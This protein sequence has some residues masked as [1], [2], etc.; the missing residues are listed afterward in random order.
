M[1]DIRGVRYPVAPFILIPSLIALYF[2]YTRPMLCLY[3]CERSS[4]FVMNIIA[5]HPCLA[6]HYT[7][8]I[9]AFPPSACISDPPINP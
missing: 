3:C 9:A 1:K 5:L 4:G 8:V 6:Q 2:V 7:L